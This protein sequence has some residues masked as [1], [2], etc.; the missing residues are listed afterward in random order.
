MRQ[1]K[2]KRVSRSVRFLK[3][4]FDFRTPYKVLLVAALQA[5]VLLPLP[6]SIL[7]NGPRS[8]GYRGR[9]LRTRSAA[10]RVRDPPLSWPYSSDDRKTPSDL[11]CAACD[12][13]R[14]E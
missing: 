3:L 13:P 10:V 9:Q 14:D 5:G 6:V 2:H 7:N 1:K 12:W 8:A 11:L 4:A